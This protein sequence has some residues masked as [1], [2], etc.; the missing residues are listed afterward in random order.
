MAQQAR[1]IAVS[2]Q[3]LAIGSEGPP[4][5]LA[6]GEVLPAGVT[7]RPAAGAAVELLLDDGRTLL[8]DD[9]LAWLV[10]AE[11]PVPSTP[12][13]TAALQAVLDVLARGGDLD[14]LEAA[15]A[16]A[17]GGAEGEGNSFVR[18]LRIVE[19][20]TPNVYEYGVEL[21]PTIDAPL[22]PQAEA[23]PTPA[24]EPA[25][26]PPPAP[27]TRALPCHAQS[28]VRVMGAGEGA[29]SFEQ[30]LSQEKNDGQWLLSDASFQ[31]ARG[32]LP[33]PF[34][35]TDQGGGRDP[36]FVVTPNFQAAPGDRLTFSATAVLDTDDRG[37]DQYQVTLYRLT[38]AGWQAAGVLTSADGSYTHT[39]DEPGE[40]RVQFAVRDNTGGADKASATVA[41]E[42]TPWFF[43]PVPGPEQ[44][45]VRPATGNLL[46]ND[47]AG[48]GTLAEHT[49]ALV[50][51]TPQPDGS[52]LVAGEQG[53]LSVAPDGG[54]TYTPSPDA[55]GGEETFSYTLTDPDGDSSTA[56][57]TVTVT[58]TVLDPLAP[59]AAADAFAA[60]EAD[61]DAGAGLA[62]AALA[63]PDADRDGDGIPDALEDEG[64]SATAAD[65]PE[66]GDLDADDGAADGAA[67]ALEDAL[68]DALQGPQA[69]TTLDDLLPPAGEAASGAEAAA[70]A[71]PDAPSDPADL[72]IIGLQLDAGPSS[73]IDLLEQQKDKGAPRDG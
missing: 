31:S 19:D 64:P 9:R 1:V 27:I 35:I 71:A 42:P 2:G 34:T 10:G 58:R 66:A 46:A 6:A 72:T 59:Q 20:V 18:L 26:P 12:Q 65:D 63:A 25:A 44:V 22:L 70:G 14:E 61:D 32:T 28:R 39:F 50:G 11:A 53:T 60:A 62:S 52:W 41:L 29:A 69:D 3:V 55:A 4:R 49:W 56:T 40:Y 8:L 48:D 57:L 30:R 54:F 17:A 68:D 37:A 13:A 45:E 73:E 23:A 47:V 51:G 67:L 7:V 36:A 21:A 15:A 24:P 38:D 5:L 33:H 16:G 43:D